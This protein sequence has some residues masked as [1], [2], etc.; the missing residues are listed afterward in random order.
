MLSVLM[1]VRKATQAAHLQHCEELLLVMNLYTGEELLRTSHVRPC[2]YVFS[3]FCIHGGRQLITPL[4]YSVCICMQ[5]CVCT[6][7]SVQARIWRHSRHQHMRGGKTSRCKRLLCAC[8][9]ACACVRLCL[10]VCVHP[11][12]VSY[13]DHAPLF[14]LVPVPV[15]VHIVTVKQLTRCDLLHPL[16]ACHHTRTRTCSKNVAL[17]ARLT[18]RPHRRNHKPHHNQAYKELC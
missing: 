17:A 13:L 8:V 11:G 15:T 4:L 14:H 18:V 6:G 12:P 9:H 1:C 7:T 10:C 5:V 16:V 3:P 2:V